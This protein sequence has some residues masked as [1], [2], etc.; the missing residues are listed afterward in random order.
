MTTKQAAKQL[1][2]TSQTIRNRL[3]KLGYTPE[4]RDFHIDTSMLE[5]ISQ[6][7]GPG[8]PTATNNETMQQTT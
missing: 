7:R 4:G 2:V 3:R 1:S 5:A 6:W 8:K